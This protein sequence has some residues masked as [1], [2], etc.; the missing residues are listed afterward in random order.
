MRVLPES[1]RPCDGIIAVN[2]GEDSLRQFV[3]TR[4]L[5][6]MFPRLL[7]HLQDVEPQQVTPG[8]TG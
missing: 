4:D 5:V 3:D 1:E 2:N 6:V 7:R 8:N